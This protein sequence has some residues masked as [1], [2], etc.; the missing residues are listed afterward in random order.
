MLP[1]TKGREATAPS[2]PECYS[3]EYYSQRTFD[4][5]SV[6]ETCFCVAEVVA[7]LESLKP[8]VQK[9]VDQINNPYNRISS[10]SSFLPS[11]FSSPSQLYAG[12]HSY[13]NPND[14]VGPFLTNRV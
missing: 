12:S 8:E 7:E 10:S 1:T 2:P 3:V 4:W 9:Q 14:K 5:F 6:S 11:D 13:G